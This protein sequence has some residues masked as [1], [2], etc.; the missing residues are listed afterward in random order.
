MV[1][2]PVCLYPIFSKC[3]NGLFNW[4]H[5]SCFASVLTITTIASGCVAYTHARP[6]PLCSLHTRPALWHLMKTS[7]VSCLIA[8]YTLSLSYLPFYSRSAYIRCLPSYL[9][10]TACGRGCDGSRSCQITMLRC[11]MFLI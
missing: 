1:C 3:A 2:L 8:F 9:P 7:V 10:N 5:N 11:W 4:F 6:A